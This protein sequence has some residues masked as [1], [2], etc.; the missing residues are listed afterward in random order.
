MYVTETLILWQYVTEKAI[1]KMLCRKI[2]F[3]SF[4]EFLKS[5]QDWYLTTFDVLPKKTSYTHLV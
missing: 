1:R 5:S 2:Q 4:I 3:R